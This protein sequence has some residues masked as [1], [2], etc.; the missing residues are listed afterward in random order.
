MRLCFLDY[1]NIVGRKLSVRNS[2]HFPFNL[3]SSKVDWHK[4]FLCWRAVLKINHCIFSMR[5][6]INGPHFDSYLFFQDFYDTWKMHPKLDVKH[7]LTFWI[8]E[9]TYKMKKMDINKKLVHWS[10]T[11]KWKFTICETTIVNL[12]TF[13]HCKTTKSNKKYLCCTVNILWGLLLIGP[14][15]QIHFI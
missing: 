12:T 10:V 13:T 3:V 11:N 9:S 14:W 2:K 1:K 15:Y 6:K 5:L 8:F 7:H 4:H